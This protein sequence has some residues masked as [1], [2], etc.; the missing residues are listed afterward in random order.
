MLRKILEFTKRNFLSLC[1]YA[2]F[3]IAGY[4]LG[5]KNSWFVIIVS[6]YMAI[7]DLLIVDSRRK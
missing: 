1:A 2:W 6:L 7:I 5:L 4:N 3:F